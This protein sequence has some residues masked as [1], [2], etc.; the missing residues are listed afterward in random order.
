MLIVYY[1]IHIQHLGTYTFKS[2]KKWIDI[3]NRPEDLEWVDRKVHLLFEQA[4]VPCP[5]IV[6]E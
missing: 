1:L 5:P 4:G 6:V 2:G 3:H